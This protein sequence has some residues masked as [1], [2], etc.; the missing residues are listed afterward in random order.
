MNETQT[1][2]LFRREAV[3]HAGNRLY[4]EVILA[5]PLSNWIVTGL[6]GLI[7]IGVAVAFAVGQYA[8]KER[9]P[10]WLTPDKGVVRIVA[11]EAGVVES[12]HVVEGASVREGDVLVTLS[13]QAGLT[14]GGAVALRLEEIDKQIDELESRLALTTEKFAHD[15]RALEIERAAAEGER[16]HLKKQQEAQEERYENS[17]TLLE[18]Y[19]SLE[20]ENA[21][22]VIEVEQ[23]RESVLGLL[24]SKEQLSQQIAAKTGAIKAV[25]AQLDAV[26]VTEAAARSE[27]RQA[28]A[29]L[30]DQRA[31]LARE[32]GVVLRAPV[33]GRVAA[34]PVRVGESVAP[35][36]L[37][38]AILPEGSR[39]EAELFVP[40]RAAG[41]I[42]TGQE[43]RLRFDAF[44][45]QTFGSVKGEISRISRTIF[46][47]DELPVSIGVTEPVYRVAVVMET[48]SMDAN[49]ERFP[50][51]AGMLLQADIVLEKQ[52]LRRLLAKAGT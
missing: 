39:L 49:G 7:V 43:V 9:A 14:A 25:E 16:E 17:K 44:P 32:G 46:D 31:R 28:L 2:E 19:V 50:L 37:Q 3:A 13:L 38:V 42:R 47:P 35:R 11:P 52:P 5:S 15:R 23:Q 20:Q 40:T 21:A 22:S 36:S 29:A 51:Q 27:I 33:A 4:G 34:L 41:F 12:V 6:I 18:S 26:P 24:Q 48:Q 1:M 8:R 10:G 30:R 45:F